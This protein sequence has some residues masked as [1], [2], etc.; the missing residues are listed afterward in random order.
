MSKILI[1]FW[2]CSFACQSVPQCRKRFPF[3][4]LIC[5]TLRVVIMNSCE[6]IR[7][8]SSEDS[9]WKTSFLSFHDWGTFKPRGT[10]VIVT[11]GI[12]AP[13]NDFLIY[14][15][16]LVW[17]FFSSRTKTAIKFPKVQLIFDHRRGLQLTHDLRALSISYWSIAQ[18]PG[19][20]EDPISSTSSWKCRLRGISIVGH[21]FLVQP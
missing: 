17:S 15:E 18:Q 12:W 7:E 5:L 3:S 10:S 1:S 16:K 11:L 4:F 9:S 8:S 2:P 20:Q 21:S 14:Y 13:F 6:V 19:T